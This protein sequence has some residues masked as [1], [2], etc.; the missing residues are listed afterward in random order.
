[1]TIERGALE[2]LEKIEAMGGALKA[3]EAGYIQSEIQ[4]SAFSYQK[5]VESGERVVVGVN[6]FRMEERTPIGAFRL[7]PALEQAQID[8]LRRVRA[9]G[10]PAETAGKLDRLEEAARFVEN[11]LPHILAAAECYATVGEISDRLRAVFG[12]HREIA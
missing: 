4:G 6:R 9:A 8:R 5:A 7:D 10:D 3:I 12:E 1:D 11:L 2:Y